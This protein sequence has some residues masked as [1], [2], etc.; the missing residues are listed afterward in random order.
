MI[1]LDL[2]EQTQ[3]FAEVMYQNLLIRGCSKIK[4]FENYLWLLQVY[5]Q[6]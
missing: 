4:F 6:I 3:P 1:W 5:S 2:Y